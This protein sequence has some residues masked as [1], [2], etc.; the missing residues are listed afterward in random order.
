MATSEGE[1]ASAWAEQGATNSASGPVAKGQHG[2]L[3]Y[4][5][6]S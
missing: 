6:M 2:N 1:S 5:D 4:W 3:R